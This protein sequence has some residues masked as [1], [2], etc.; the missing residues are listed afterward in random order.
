MPLE[1]HSVPS[2]ILCSQKVPSLDQKPRTSCSVFGNC[3]EVLVKK[4]VNMRPSRHINIDYNKVNYEI[5]ISVSVCVMEGGEER[6]SQECGKKGT[7]SSWRFGGQ[8]GR[9]VVG[10]TLG[11]KTG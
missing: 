11:D 5:E 2:N 10:Q 7:L 1:C 8:T 4:Q 6:K 3:E 9:S